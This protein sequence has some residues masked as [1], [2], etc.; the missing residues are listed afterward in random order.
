[1]YVD[2]LSFNS[3]F[4]SLSHGYSLLCKCSL[5]VLRLHEYLS[6][7]DFILEGLINFC[8]INCKNLV[9]HLKVIAVLDVSHTSAL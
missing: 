3:P 4:G 9:G 5:P 7:P 1:M 6:T 2:T 8:H